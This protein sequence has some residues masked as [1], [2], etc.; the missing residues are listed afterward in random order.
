MGIHTAPSPESNCCLALSEGSP[1]IHPAS[2]QL[3][4]ASASASCLPGSS[5]EL[6]G[7]FFVSGLIHLSVLYPRATCSVAPDDSKARP[8]LPLLSACCLKYACT[9][10]LDIKIKERATSWHVPPAPYHGPESNQ[11]TI[12]LLQPNPTVGN[13]IIYL[14]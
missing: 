7:A 13:W 4:I 8:R 11:F 3:T 14:R 1:L 5:R 9:P 6:D 10:S 12:Y 2:L